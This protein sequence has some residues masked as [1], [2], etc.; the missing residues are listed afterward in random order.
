M[1]QA[2]LVADVGGEQGKERGSRRRRRGQ[3][4]GR[5]LVRRKVLWGN[6][7]LQSGGECN[8]KER[9]RARGGDLRSG[10]GE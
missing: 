7:R 10:G 5:G 3:V 1:R 8:G 6:R 4:R 2:V 9:E